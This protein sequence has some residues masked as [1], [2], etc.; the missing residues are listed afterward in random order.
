M[1]LSPQRGLN[2]FSPLS[3]LNWRRLGLPKKG[4]KK[5]E[6]C[7]EKKSEESKPAS[8]TCT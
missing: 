7:E 6:K 1:R 2:A 5:E 4:K 8:G 3:D